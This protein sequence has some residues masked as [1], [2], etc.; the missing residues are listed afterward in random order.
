MDR[1]RSQDGELL[2]AIVFAQSY[3]IIDS[4]NFICITNH[5]PNFLSWFTTNKHFKNMPVPIQTEHILESDLL[6]DKV[7]KDFFPTL[8]GLQPIIEDYQPLCRDS[9]ILVG[10]LQFYTKGFLF[11]DNRQGPY[12]VPFNDVDEFKFHIAS[13]QEAS[14]MEVRL[15]EAGRNKMPNN[16]ITEP[17]FFI[18]VPYEFVAKRIAKFTKLI[19]KEEKL[20]KERY[21]AEMAKA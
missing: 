20:C 16:L 17:R 15:N 8:L 12:V 19:E 6:G 18:C 13:E 14:W 2:G 1:I 7:Q 9:L 3:L 11:I 4:S 5:V 21:D 10:K